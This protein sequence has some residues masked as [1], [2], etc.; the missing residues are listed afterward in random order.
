MTQTRKPI[1]LA[2]VGVG[3]IARD[4]HLPTIAEDPAFT[5][6]AT[7]TRSG[8]LP[9][10]PNFPTINEALKS[11]RGIDAYVLCTPP[12]GRC[13]QAHAIIAAGL[14]VFL[15]KPPGASLTEVIGLQRQ[16]GERGVT[17]F[18]SWHSRYAAGVAPARAWLADKTVRSVTI[19]W[20]EDVRQW[21]PGQDWIFAVGGMGVFDPGINALS[22][23]TEILPEP[24][25]ITRAALGIPANRDTPIQADLQGQLASGGQF[26][27]TFD[28]LHG[29]EQ[30][31]DIR[32]ETD[33][34]NLIL[35]N[36]GAKLAIAGIPVP[37][38]RASEYASL[39]RRFA[40]LVD[41]R[42]SDVDIAPFVH[43]ADAFMLGV[44]RKL[45][46]FD[47]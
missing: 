36:G 38:E 18:A 1:A 35:R 29:D 22:I 23:A 32:V 44:R 42:E 4:Q 9:N 34:G 40:R 37:L 3:K 8:E 28:F 24:F 45:P 46:T 15:E 30:R 27:A 43:V 6:V 47:W 12:A 33:G 20:K 10:T 14:P 26:Q 25:A 16:A 5:L 39:Y 11:D 19:D 21:H 2:L 31:W 7:V 13:A 17:L 41:R